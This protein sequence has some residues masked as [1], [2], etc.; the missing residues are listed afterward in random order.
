MGFLAGRTRPISQTE[1][2]T[3]GVFAPK[4]SGSAD[5]RGVVFRPGPALMVAAGFV[6]TAMVSCVKV[7]R[8]ELSAIE[9]VAWRGLVGIPAALMMIRG[10]RFLPT[11]S[12]LVMLRVVAGFVAMTCFYTAAHGLTVA[13]LSLLGRLQP[14]AIALIAPVV[15]GVG[16]RAGIRVWGLLCLGVAGTAVLLVPQLAVGNRYGLWALGAVG[17][18]TIAHL[19][20][21]ALRSTDDPRCIV[22]WFQVGGTAIAVGWLLV[23][24]GT[25]LSL[26]S[27]AMWPW[28]AG[29]GLF[30]T[31]GQLLMTKAYAL[32]RAAVVSAA[33]HTSPV[34]A[35][36]ADVVLFA[37]IPGARTIVGGGILLAA[38]LALIFSPDDKGS[39]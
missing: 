30:G 29:V 23:T 22:L 18:S 5:M 6:F 20:L 7:A 16:E 28:I 25:N 38:A 4:P 21:R 37:D 15:L 2:H 17:A 9:I 19:T 8:A 12:R 32:D 33:S 10:T 14:V 1:L 34:W 26:P 13:D 27:P 36:V 24:T 11:H 39:T 31:V 3:S 35:V